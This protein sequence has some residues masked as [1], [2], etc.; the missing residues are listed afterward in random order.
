MASLTASFTLP[1]SPEDVW[2]LFTARGERSWVKGWDPVFPGNPDDRQV[3]TVFT[4]DQGGA[5]TTW[6]VTAAEPG[7]RIGYARVTPNTTAGTVLV[8]CRPRSRSDTEVTVGYRLTALT[9]EAQAGLDTFGEGYADYIDSWR[10]AILQADS[11]QRDCSDRP[12]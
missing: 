1:M 11:A 3:G 10:D 9:P 4:T 2:P 12:R 6:V 5:V 7:H 8:T